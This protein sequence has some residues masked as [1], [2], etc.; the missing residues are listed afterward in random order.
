VPG[1]KLDK[2]TIDK[3]WKL[4][5]FKPN[6]KQ[7]EAI[8]HV[9]GP[10]FLAAGPG[11]GKTRVLLWR[12]LNLL[13]YHHI[14][15]EEI[16]LSTFTEKAAYQLRDGLRSLLGIV[17][18]E[19][20]IPFDISKMSLGTIHSIC[21]QMLV[22]RRFS[23][24]EKRENQPI[25]LDALGQ[26]FRLY[27]RRNWKDLIESAGYKEEEEAQRD[28][29]SY[30]GFDGDSNYSRHWA[31]QNTIGLF[32]RLSEENYDHKKIKITDKTLKKLLKMYSGYKTNLESD[33]C[34]DFSLL[35]QAAFNRVQTCEGSK[36]VFKHVIIDEYQDT[37]SIQESLFFS[38]AGGNKNICVVGDDDQ[39][40][41]RFRGATVENLVNFEERCLE[42]LGEK[43][44]RIDLNINYRSRKHI[45]D[46]YTDYMTKTDWQKEG[47]KKGHYRV[48]DKDIKPDSKDKGIA[49][50][51]TEK[52]NAEEVFKS[53]AKFVKS[54]KTKGVITDYNQVAFLFP[55]MKSNSRVFG[56]RKAF[57]DLKISVYAPRAGRFLEVEESIKVFGLIQMIFGGPQFT[58]RNKTSRGMR[59]FQQWLGL[60]DTT[61]KELVKADK[62]LKEFI[63]DRQ[64]EVE[65]I[66]ND[67]QILSDILKRKKI[68]IDKSCNL[69]LIR[70][71][72]N[73]ASL[74]NK[75]KKNL[76]NRFFIKI[77]KKRIEENKAFS[78][79]YIINRATSLDWGVLD[80]F[81]QLNGFKYFRDLYKLAEN[82]DD[83]GPI[84]N[85]GL[86][87]QYLSKFME[88]YTPLITGSFA[89]EGKF[90]RTFFSSFCYAL[91]RLGESEYEDID[92]PFPKGRIPFLTIH[93]S[94]G[95]EFP[96]VVLGSVYKDDNKFPYV[97]K[98]VRDLKPNDEAE[99]IERINE[100]DRMRM[101]YVALSRAQNLLILPRYTHGKAASEPFK[102]ILEEDKLSKIKDFDI[103]TLPEID[104]KEHD[105]GKT[106]SYTADY[107]DYKKCPRN[108]MIFRN[109]GFIPSRSQTM[110]FGSLVH[111]TIEDL[112]HYLKK[113]REQA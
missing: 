16:F 35:Q 41:Y 39:A 103:S 100:F 7:E 83:E 61:A 67:Y 93:Q 40:L 72:S 14:K 71:F 11:S 62:Q 77:L 53:I 102:T 76:T 27:N 31:V 68:D 58:E 113:K 63:K 66:I 6:S 73:A 21:Q 64:M 4:A 18:N 84:C 54:L 17:T 32:N 30:F 44:K 25:I 46:F 88:E 89:S 29:N 5:E 70:D 43:S 42:H 3:L 19:T 109:Y 96:V 34:V 98:I 95:L 105:L 106:Y 56:F 15:P 69:D 80:L 85:L 38:L 99:P 45:V 9:N 110:F 112:H 10:L 91:F 13:V 82:G 1:V 55:A 36:K 104:A 47:E 20:G 65:T 8:L 108:Y 49:V 26:Y 23:T 37:N 81:Y 94:K 51:T 86:I 24:E 12:T 48:V 107:L 79:R 90:Y 52:E 59:E 92:D 2:I 57:E 33:R 60:C 101:F 28:I 97:E 22:D 74:S 111:Q 50:L 75:A 87:T 78:I